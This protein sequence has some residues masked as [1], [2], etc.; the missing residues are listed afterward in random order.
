MK[1]PHHIRVFRI[2][3]GYVV[4]QVRAVVMPHPDPGYGKPVVVCAEKRG[5]YRIGD[6]IFPGDM[7]FEWYIS[8]VT[9]RDQQFLMA[10]GYHFR[11][12]GSSRKR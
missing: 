9:E 7:D 8:N 4:F 2:Q 3:G 1:K 10:G 12:T 11:W 6:A 5:G